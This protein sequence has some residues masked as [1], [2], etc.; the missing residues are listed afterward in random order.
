MSRACL[1]GVTA[2]AA[3]T[4]TVLGQSTPA[5]A[6]RATTLHVSPDGH[7]TAC[8]VAHPC[9]IT[10]AKAKVRTLNSDMRADIVVQLAGG[11]YRLAVPLTFTR[12]DSGTNGHRVV[13]Q[14]A[15]GARPLISGAREAT[16]WTR[17]DPTKNIWK[18]KVG[19]GFDI[20]QLYVDGVQ[21][22]RARTQLDRADL[23]ADANGY[24]F[25]SGALKY[26]NSL[27]DPGRT[28]IDALGSFTNRYS[29][30]AGIRD[31]VITMKQP[32]WNNNTF[33]YDTITNPFR[34]GPLYIE[35]AYEFLDSAGE[36]YLNTR[37]GTLYY[38]PLPGQDM[39]TADVEMPRLESLLSVGGTYQAPATHITFSGLQF[40]HTSWLQPSTGQ[41][42]ANQQTGAFVHG[43]W[44]RPA[45]A[46]DSCQYGCKLFEATRPH[47]HQ[48]PAAVQVSAAS[49]I[50]FTGNWFTQLGQVALGIGNDAN[51]HATGVG[52]GADTISVSG[53][54]FSQGA[55]GGVVVGGVQADAHHPG[56]SRMTNRN[57]TIGNNV[58][59]DLAL[60]YRDMTAVLVTYATNATVSHNE[61]YEMP[62]TGIAIGYGWG[63]NDPGGSQDYVNRG[64]YDFQ[65]VHTTPTTL[66]NLRIT[67]NYLHDVMRTMDDGAC[68]YTLS[69][70]P[71]TLIDRNYC[72]DNNGHYGIYH[73]EG[74]RDYTDSNNVFRNTG[75]WDHENSN[76]TNNTGA[77]TVTDNWTSNGS[78]SLSDGVRGNRVTGTV[79]VTDDNWPRGA[80]QVMK[81]AGV[82]V[83]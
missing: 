22:T 2:L 71:G 39:S 66:K 82:H 45:D 74:S 46:L 25:T 11:T 20:R 16:G 68:I 83:R 62:Y 23:T 12:A 24:T 26:L 34:K 42:Y 63:T 64:L 80:R 36:W 79:V 48:M 4:A 18:A 31:G 77:L 30:V 40:S 10:E 70:A 53:N 55:G 59:H 5:F 67:G 72:A 73:D 38:K 1:T 54:V 37:T 19:T 65:P 50:S 8:S 7:G 14:A 29:P 61:I 57:I 47:W 32:A 44:Q 28:E 81:N 41:G 43:D 33:G 52:L 6:S 49:H 78:I 3:V 15:P 13:W 51:A 76:A 17:Q 69:A 21:A 35:N 58:M 60:D 27:A 75:D 56:D 9:S